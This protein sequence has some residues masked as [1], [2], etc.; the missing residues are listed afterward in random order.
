M[1]YVLT[2]RLRELLKSIPNIFSTTGF[3][4]VSKI[5][6]SGGVALNCAANY[7]F[8]DFY[9]R[10]SIYIQPA[11]GDS[12]LALGAALLLCHEHGLQISV[13]KNYCFGT[14]IASNLTEEV[15]RYSE[16]SIVSK[17]QNQTLKIALQKLLDNKIIAIACTVF[18]LEPK[19]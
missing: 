19:L 4:D 11:A 17:E 10:D 8:N 2:R 15:E 6:Y 16:I 3:T 14:T 5:V 18:S 9:D 1:Q 7:T 13:A 12:G